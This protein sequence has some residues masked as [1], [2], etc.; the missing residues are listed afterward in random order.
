MTAEQNPAVQ[1]RRARR[2]R[3]R[4]GPWIASGAAALFLALGITGALLFFDAQKAQAN[5][6]DAAVT[7]RE[8]RS[9]VLAGD[10]AAIEPALAGLQQQTGAAVAAT[11]G[12]HWWLAAHLPLIGPSVYAVQTV[13]SVADSLATDTLPRLTT[14]AGVLDPEILL[15]RDGAVELRP[16]IDVAPDVVA[17]DDAVQ[18]AV[19][20]LGEINTDR[21]IERVAGPVGEVRA[22]VDEVAMT[23]ATASRAAQLIP[24]MLGAYGER[25]YVVL[26]ESNAEIRT[27]GGFV[28]SWNLITVD[29]GQITIG[30]AL[31]SSRLS[32]ESPILP[33]TE[34]EEAIYTDRP[35]TY[36][37]NVTMNA[38]FPRTAETARAM[39]ENAFGVRPDGVVALDPVALQYL[40]GAAGPVT[41]TDGTVL[42]GS[43][44]AQ[45]LLN[46]IYIDEVDPAKQDEF[47][48]EASKAIVTELMSGVENVQGVIDAL[49]AAADEGRLLLWSA[50]PAEQALLSGTV[51]SGEL[52]GEDDGAP[53][54]GVYL[55]DSSAT[56]MS[57][58]LDYSVDV[59]SLQ[60]LADGVRQLR[61]TITVTS[62]APPAASDFPPYLSGGGWIVPGDVRTN[63]HVYSPSFGFI[64]DFAVDGDSTVPRAYFTHGD[65][66]VVGTTMVLTPGETSVIEVTLETGTQQELPTRVRVTPG[67]RPA[68]ISVDDSTC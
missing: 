57:Y 53:I 58:Y 37:G 8:L 55:N 35:V 26:A 45:I 23:T 65:M 7:I 18:A 32:V 67:A 40:L 25:Q 9:T 62:T 64:E 33:L 20:R 36:A 48:G 38:D 11:S 44:A 13:S 42:D 16:F 30:D 68:A 34:E 1:T 5:L 19:V 22:L 3:R 56:K 21:L 31:P 59:Q 2:R 54:V 4:P 24:T 10:P 46:Q 51:L 61:A 41:M 60:C 63:V 12:P 15:P 50:D 43:N 47:F 29:N 39:W 49:D 28:G 14:V 27:L 17:A 52:R 6:T 66:D